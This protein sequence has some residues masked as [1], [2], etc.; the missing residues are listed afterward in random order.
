MPKITRSDSDVDEKRPVATLARDEPVY[1]PPLSINH[2]Q[3]EN[4]LVNILTEL[5]TQ[6]KLLQELVLHI[7]SL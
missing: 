2:E 3:P 1:I 6:T 5:K 7:T 4:I